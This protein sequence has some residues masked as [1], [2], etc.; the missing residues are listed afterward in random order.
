MPIGGRGGSFRAPCALPQ[1]LDE[2]SASSS[3]EWCPGTLARL[4]RQIFACYRVQG[5]LA[6]SHRAQTDVVLVAQ[7]AG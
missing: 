2:T 4:N 6:G 5:E 3:G 1:M 7:T